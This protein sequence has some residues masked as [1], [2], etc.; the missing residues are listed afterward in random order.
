MEMQD[1][2]RL[3]RVAGEV[4]ERHGSK[5]ITEEHVRDAEK[6]IEH[7]RVVEALKNLT[8]H[9]KLVLLSVY[10]LSKNNNASATTGEIYDVYNELCAETGLNLLTQ[11]RLGTLIN[12]LDVMGLLNSKVVSMGRYGRTKKI[13]LEISRSHIQDVLGNEE[14]IA[15]LIKYHPNALEKS[16]K[17]K[18]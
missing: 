15:P 13:R 4:A 1:A 9:S 2:L 8:L 18:K 16:T 7:N 10:H 6:H 3:L 12:E 5:L 17:P 11:R 14:R